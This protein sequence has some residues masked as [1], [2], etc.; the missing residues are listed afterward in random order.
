MIDRQDNISQ[1]TYNDTDLTRDIDYLIITGA[2]SSVQFGVNGNKI[3]DMAGLNKAI[4]N[5]TSSSHN[6]PTIDP[7]DLSLL[8]LKPQM[9]GEEF[10]RTLGEFLQGYAAFKYIDPLVSR[11]LRQSIPAKPQDINDWYE[12]LKSRSTEIRKKITRIMFNQ[13]CDKNFH[14]E[15]AKKYYSLFHRE[16]GIDNKTKFAY[17]TT[18]Y[19]GLIEGVLFDL[20]YRPEIGVASSP[21]QNSGN[22]QIL[23][24]E[25]L[26]D[27]ID[28]GRIPVL[29]LHGKIGWYE[30][31]NQYPHGRYIVHNEFSEDIG[32]PI[33]QLPD[34]DKGYDDDIIDQI[35]VQ[36]K[37]LL[38]RA[39][40]IVILGHSL[41]DE[42]LIQT[43]RANTD[44]STQVKVLLFARWT[45]DSEADQSSNELDRRIN[46]LEPSEKERVNAYVSKIKEKLPKAV[47]QP[48]NGFGS[49]EKLILG[50][51]DQTQ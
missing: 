45:T 42:Y 17:A 7:N 19:D 35:W 16:L 1:N 36:F 2:G 25:F 22:T 26:A 11:D 3:V 32:T 27:S 23:D 15:K 28:A 33:L 18:N 43:L 29:H 21:K 30:T 38:S 46:T 4:C 5:D 51:L 8:G 49:S 40:Q 20:K 34:P 9:T 31:E 13:F 6:F 47:I 10:E 37:I 12:N 14:F 48:I 41:N 50:S 39:R 44:S 24:I